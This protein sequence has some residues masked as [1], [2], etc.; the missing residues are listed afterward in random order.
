[1][2]SGSG[3]GKDL[4]NLSMHDL[5]R[6]EAEN[7]TAI[8]AQGLLDLEKDS[9]SMDQLE[10]LM[11]ASHSVKGAARI[12]GIDAVVALAHELEDCFVAAQ[13]RQ[14]QLTSPHIDLFLQVVDTIVQIA[15]LDEA[16]TRQWI[17]INTDTIDH[18]KTQL[19][20][21][22]GGGAQ[23]SDQEDG[24]ATIG[25]DTPAPAPGNV[26]SNGEADQSGEIG[27]VPAIHN[28]SADDRVIRI[29]ADRLTRIMGLSSE[30]LVESTWLRPFTDSMVLLKKRHAEMSNVLEALKESVSSTAVSERA[31]TQ[32]QE[33][34]KKLADCRSMLAERVIELDDYD[35]R[36]S[37]LSSNMYNEVVASR[38][39][40]FSDG[41][42]DMRRMVRDMARNLKK[43]VDLHIEG[44][45][46][47]VDR[48]ILE[49]VKAPL[50]HLL[51][52]AVDHGI[53]TPR[54]RK[55]RNKSEEGVIRLSASHIGGMLTIIV[56]DD[57]QGVD[58][59]KL[60]K[61]IVARGLTSEQI[62]ANM[63]EAE[64]LEFLFL[65]DF[66]TKTKV[67]EFSGRGVGL[68][69]V[70]NLVQEMHG[71]VNIVNDTGRGLKFI[72][73]LPL[74]LSVITTLMVEIAGEPYAFPLSRV[75]HLLSVTPEQIKTVEGRQYIS[76][77]DELIG[78]ISAAHV[79]ELESVG[80]R[81]DEFH[82]IIIG[83]HLSRYGVVVDR[84]IG[85][86]ELS[87]Q[88]L[89]ARLGKVQDISAASLTEDGMPVL[90][91]DVDDLV[92]SIDAMIRGGPL[93]TLKPYADVLSPK[94][95]KRILVVDDSLTVREIERKLLESYGYR[96]D[97]A[98]DGM[99]GWNVVRR[100]KY[101]LVLTDVDMPRMDGIELVNA[102]KADSQLG[103]IPIMI[104]SY[105]DRQEDRQRG[106][107]AGADYYLTKGS[108]QD[109]TLIE[110]V[111][112]LIGEAS[113]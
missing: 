15:H 37:N 48:D 54:V 35:R 3:N 64:L 39:R 112:D 4:S 95:R 89:D 32:L 57:G 11:R 84:F 25:D 34:Q 60:K 97:V 2:S 77:A 70:R 18:L 75:D 90:V 47:P 103:S 59:G 17:Q 5:F 53:E 92:R 12:V 19:A 14:L 102:I 110:A 8:L 63:S 82:V 7:Q 52:N 88:S 101:D 16:E 10:T 61:K 20:A 68:D 44:E 36:N 6:M 73:Q 26:L 96:V 41:V 28:K 109:E 27:A 79:L 67:T 62:A 45:E 83:D 21:V 55:N 98:V 13:R 40:P 65:P 93:G 86:R 99:D 23:F 31:R 56:E 66:T 105:K 106:L 85:Q 72:L 87:V 50:T 30:I 78:L 71:K 24:V 76:L 91:I 22:L 81:Y 108:F 42:P 80:Q 43:K 69:V 1:M 100:A 33:L 104:V 51:R 58:L 107:E 94:V 74:T 49:R 113:E 38:M 29:S 46:T 9:A 111:V